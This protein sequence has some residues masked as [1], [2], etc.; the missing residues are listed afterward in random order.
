MPL[1][2]V[3]SQI[4]WSMKFT[5]INRKCTLESNSGKILRQARFVQI[6]TVILFENIPLDAT[7]IFIGFQFAI[8]IFSIYTA[9]KFGAKPPLPPFG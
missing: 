9:K 4:F 2:L 7:E 3:L 8:S 5:F 6:F 1:Y